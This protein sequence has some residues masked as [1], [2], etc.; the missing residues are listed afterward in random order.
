MKLY[1]LSLLKPTA[2]T[3]AVY[4]SFT[5]PKTHE[6]AVIRGT[7]LELLRPDTDTLRIETVQ[8]SEAFGVLRCIQPLR[9]LGQSIDHL[10]V[11]SDSGNMSVLLFNKERNEWQVVHC[12]AFGKSGIRRVTPGQYLAREP[13]GR[14]FMVAALEK[15]KLVYVLNRAVAS[16][17]SSAVSLSSNTNPLALTI[18]S[19]LEAHKSRVLLFDVIGLDNGFDNPIFA[20]LELDYG[21]SDMDMSGES[22]E[23][24]QKTLTY[25]ELDLGINHVVKKWSRETDRG[26]NMLIPVP[27]DVDGPGGCLVLCENWIL[28]EHNVGGGAS[29][30]GTA[31][32]PVRTAIPRRTDMPDSRGLLLVSWTMHKSK[33]GFFFLVQSELGDLYKVTLVLSAPTEAVAGVIPRRSVADLV[34]KY[35]DTIP[36]SNSLCL[37]RSG[38]LF[39]AAEF[40]NHFLFQFKSLGDDGDLAVSSKA[41]ASDSSQGGE[42]VHVD[43][44]VFAP[45]M[46]R[47]L[48]KADESLSLAPITDMR[49]FVPSVSSNVASSSG[50]PQ[51][52][53]LCG[54]GPRSSFRVLRQGLGANE[55]AV[56]AMPGTPL[57][58][59]TLKAPGAFVA[60]AA[61]AS[62]ATVAAAGNATSQA[63]AAAAT[64]AAASSAQGQPDRYIVLSFSNASVV[65]SVGSSVEEVPA[66]DIGFVENVQT[67]LAGLLVDGSYIQVYPAAV[68]IV[69]FVASTGAKG[70]AREWK[71]PGR[72]V[73][74]HAAMNSRQLVL[75]I[76]GGEIIYFEFDAASRGLKEIEKKSLGAEITA[77]A[78]GPIP[79]GR[80]RNSFCAVADTSLM[81]RILALDPDKHLEQVSSQALRAGAE[82]LAI[83]SIRIHG[84]TVSPHLF[85][86]LQNGVL[87]RLSLD[88]RSGVL[89]D[90]RVR[91]LGL[92]PVKLMQVLIAGAQALMALSSRA[93][94]AYNLHGR[95]LMQPISLDG[96][97]GSNTNNSSSS[98]VVLEHASSF[99]T[100]SLPEAF[101]AVAGTSLRILTLDRLGEPF[102]ARSLPF[103][104]TPRRMAFHMT[105]GL[106]AVV[107]A[108]HNAFNIAER[109]EI[110]M[111]SA[112]THPEETTAAGLPSFQELLAKKLAITNDMKDSIMNDVDTKVTTQTHLSDMDLTSDG[113]LASETNANTDPFEGL[114]TRRIGVPLPEEQGKWASCIRL[115]DSSFLTSSSSSSSSAA[116]MDSRTTHHVLELS[117]NEAALSVATASFHDLGDEH[118]VFVGVVQGLSFHPRKY[119]SCSIHAYQV[120]EAPRAVNDVLGSAVSSAS[121]SSSSF[122]T[123]KRFRLELV[124]KTPVEDLPLALSAFQGRLLVGVGR[125]LRLYDMGK[126]RLLRKCELK[127]AFPTGVQNIQT[128]LDRAVVSDQQE[129]LHFVKYHQAGNALSLFA[130]DTIM[131]HMTC[132][133]LL[134]HD[135]VIGADKFGSVFVLR[136]P[137]EVSDL[138]DG[139]GLTMI[140]ADATST[141]LGGA[142]NKVVQIAHFY[143]GS[144][145]T[146]LQ[147]AVL[148]VGGAEVVLYTTVHGGLGALSPLTSKDDVDLF[149]KLELAMRNEPNI[150]IVN[151]DHLSFRSSFAP[152]SH[153]I[154]GDLIETFSRLTFDR[155]KTVAGFAD[156]TPVDVS[157]KIEDLRNR[158]T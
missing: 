125:T 34:V 123:T 3:Q 62:A 143:V 128:S 134:D 77:L 29:G 53:T 40:G 80:V 56:S 102:C 103:R 71:P 140:S 36:T 98:S 9:F 20:C 150:S 84:P 27:G 99:T 152:V 83:V 141:L 81:V 37:T 104:Y 147:K 76:S 24:A 22:T 39:A 17:S 148:A 106:I 122:P 21:D 38:L 51:I 46:L 65:L 10:L 59:F 114:D 110:A 155:Q 115:V 50:A 111:K 153:V 11:T 60:A 69:T 57:S 95:F 101:V 14:A 35:F 64:A 113:L 131:R 2:I 119:K 97:L 121:N 13:H 25:Y 5:G 44:P 16:G 151:R 117:E 149:T 28:Y 30:S 67:L 26:A 42:H 1:N 70:P 58:V 112:E 137:A 32:A 89:S 61:A 88:E 4:G 127:N 41:V 138:V 87:S 94:V 135:T 78:L 142:A 107:E 31:P 124:H 120:V 12:E 85:I 96:P 7:T 126:K 15:Q 54:R 132:S 68:R 157:K 47:N 48:I 23:L 145:V 19:P 146:S 130:D 8:S 73:I 139:Q 92:R 118:F 144:V 52:L 158:M 43:V 79:E 133:L 75:A 109:R 33:S 72:R 91:F 86:G 108:D 93:F 82:S 154:D 18:S 55:L 105:T 66:K 74:V 156:R 6:F 100:D 49:V 63:L 116:Y 90:P 45:R 136:L 129:S